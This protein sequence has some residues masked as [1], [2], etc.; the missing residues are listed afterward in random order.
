M[1]VWTLFEQFDDD[2]RSQTVVVA[3]TADELKR[4]LDNVTSVA[5]GAVVRHYEQKGTGSGHPAE[6]LFEIHQS[7]SAAAR[8]RNARR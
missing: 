6:K 7:R 3:L 2:Q 4:V 8:L 1:A 5:V